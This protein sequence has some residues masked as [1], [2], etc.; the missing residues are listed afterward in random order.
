MPTHAEL[1]AAPC[2][3]V[4]CKACGGNGEYAVDVF[5]KYSGP[6][7]SDDLDS[8]ESCDVCDGGGVTETCDRCNELGDY[9][10]E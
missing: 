7:R 9:E 8:Y 3:C 6:S 10:D 5:G 1:L 2:Q 4:R